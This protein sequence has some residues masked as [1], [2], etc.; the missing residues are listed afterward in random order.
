ME[1]LIQVD[2]QNETLIGTPIL[3]AYF[4]GTLVLSGGD[5]PGY[6]P[7]DVKVIFYATDPGTPLATVDTFYPRSS[8]TT[9]A[10]EIDLSTVDPFGLHARIQWRDSVPNTIQIETPIGT[11]ENLSYFD[12][13]RPALELDFVPV[14]YIGSPTASL[15]LSNRGLSSVAF[16]SGFPETALPVL[17]LS[18]NKFQACPDWPLLAT[19][20]DLSNNVGM[21][22]TVDLTERTSLTNLDLSDCAMTS[23][24]VDEWVDRVWDAAGAGV[25]AYTVDLSGSNNAPGVDALAKVTTLN[26]AG[27]TITTS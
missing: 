13:V 7:D 3:P 6:L 21:R 22:N 20:V 17:N 23:A 24:L 15:D 10:A 16:N 5:D 1:A 11:G 19:S 25:T 18:Q 27:W 2:F 9:F 4:S 26:A 8:N 12:R 14:S